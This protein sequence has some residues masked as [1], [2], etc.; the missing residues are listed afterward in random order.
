MAERIAE[1]LE[2]KQIF[3]PTDQTAAADPTAGVWLDTAGYTSLD[4]VIQLGA[5]AATK[6]AEIE[7]YAADDT[8]GTNAA[9][10]DDDTVTGAT[11]NTASAIYVISIDVIPSRKRYVGIKI[12]NTLASGSLPVAALLIGKPRKKPATVI[13]MTV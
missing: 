12:G 3:L 11:G 6:K 13:D 2:Y 5:I 10:I 9:K 4:I 1:G 7:L 8:S